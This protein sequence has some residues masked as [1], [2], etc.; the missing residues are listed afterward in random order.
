MLIT[1]AIDDE[2]FYYCM[3]DN[4]YMTYLNTNTSTTCP[5]IKIKASNF[6]E[7]INKFKQLLDKSYKDIPDLCYIK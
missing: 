1:K 5:Q 4:I 7:A 2:G 3:N 6:K